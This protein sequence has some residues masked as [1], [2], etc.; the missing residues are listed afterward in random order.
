MSVYISPPQSCSFL[1]LFIT[2]GGFSF[3]KV[4]GKYHIIQNRVVTANLM[5]LLPPFAYHVIAVLEIVFKMHLLGSRKVTLTLSRCIF[6]EF[7][8]AR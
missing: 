7:N 4:L 6:Q 1:Y 5:L 3:C 2:F 8:K